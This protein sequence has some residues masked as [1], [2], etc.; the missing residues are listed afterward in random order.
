[1]LLNLS[2]LPAEDQRRNR[3]VILGNSPPCCPEAS[4]PSVGY[5]IPRNASLNSMGKIPSPSDPQFD[6]GGR[7]QMPISALTFHE[8]R[9]KT[10]LVRFDDILTRIIQP[11]AHVAQRRE[12]VM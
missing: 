7:S 6:V 12:T 10:R 5:T 9:L 8:K 1:M 2:F 3:L 4:E 11:V